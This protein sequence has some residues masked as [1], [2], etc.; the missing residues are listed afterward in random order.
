MVFSTILC[1]FSLSLACKCAALAKELGF[2]G[3]GLEY[4]GECY[5][6]T[7]EEIDALTKGAD[8]KKHLCVGDQTYTV[9]EE[10]HDFCVGK[11]NAQAVYV[12]GKDE[13]PST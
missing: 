11:D 7:Q 2:P 6:K 13:E 5:A 10:S 3:F 4:Y 1:A 12:F 8:A 9:C